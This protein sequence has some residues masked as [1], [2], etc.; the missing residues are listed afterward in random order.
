MKISTDTRTLEPGDVFIPIKGPNFDGYAYIDEA[1]RKGASKILDVDLVS[2]AKS[3]RKKL[4]CPVI[5]ITGSAG[6]TTVKDMLAAVLGTRYTIVKTP[7]NNNNE[8]G[9]PLTILSADANTDVLIVELGMR[10][11]GQ[12]AGLAKMLRPTHTVIT[13]IGLTHIE[14]LQ[15]QRNIALA[16]AEIFQPALSWERQ[17]RN[18][19]IN[20]T[21]PYFDL[22]SK[23]AAKAGYKLYPFGGENKPDQNLNL[24]YLVGRHFGLTDEKIVEGLSRYAPSKHRLIL[25][26]LGALTLI[27][28]TYNANPDG[29]IYSL[30]Y[31]KRFS[32][33]KILVMGDMLELGDIADAEHQKIVE[34]ALDADVSIIY[35]TGNHCRQ[36]RSNDI[37][38]YWFETK[39]EL[40]THLAMELKSNDIV[41]VKGSRGMKMEDCVTSLQ[42]RYAG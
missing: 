31:L 2:Y 7:E 24:C 18:A 35:A 14:R 40:N 16:K 32:G 26:K 4:T 27:D 37:P 5:G 12:I 34:H 9:V 30:Q 15:T 28:D 25:H 3:Y 41:L 17:Q 21:T 6:K 33:R 1:L 20:H 39:K 23:K 22:L 10:G 19:F 38:V 42:D 29:F 13:S 11:R 8:I 36:I